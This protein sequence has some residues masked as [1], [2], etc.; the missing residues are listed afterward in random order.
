MLAKHMVFA[1]VCIFLGDMRKNPPSKRLNKQSLD[2]ARDST[3]SAPEIARPAPFRYLE[4]I[5]DKDLGVSQK[6]TTSELVPCQL[7][8]QKKTNK[9][10]SM[11]QPDFEYWIGLADPR[12]GQASLPVPQMTSAVLAQTTNG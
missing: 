12:A 2:L 6:P 8:F 10:I 1:N 5:A 4:P 7:S 11:V 9:V 3:T